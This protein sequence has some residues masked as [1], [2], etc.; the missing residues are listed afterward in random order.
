MMVRVWNQNKPLLKNTEE[1]WEHMEEISNF[2]KGGF[3]VEEWN[4]QDKCFGWG[5]QLGMFLFLVNN[6]MRLKTIWI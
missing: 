1:E 6:S 5:K 4:N 3:G 2:Q